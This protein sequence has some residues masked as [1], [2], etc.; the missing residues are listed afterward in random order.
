MTIVDLSEEYLGTY[1][2]CLE[3]WSPELKDAGPHKRCWYEENRGRGLRVKLAKDDRGLI[4]GM[5]QYMP[6][7]RSPIVGEG[8]YYIYCV[9]V[10]G[11]AMGVGNNQHRGIGKRLLEAA[12]EDARSLG[13]KG[14]VAWGLRLPLFMRSAW[15]KRQG[16][17]KVDSDGLAELVFKR[18]SPDAKRPAF[19]KRRVALQ[20]GK[21]RVKITSFINGWCPAQNLVHERAKR[22]AEE[23]PDC[24]EFERIDT[25]TKEKM[26]EYGLTDA[27]YIDGRQVRTG[28]PPSYEK[29]KK[30]VERRVRK[31]GLRPARA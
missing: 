16:Y 9:W 3:E 15:F 8:L 21:D 1:C 20:P 7:E 30:L 31:R 19:I 18:F 28:P 24:V 22:V 2:Q 13:A 5:I 23:S 10:H 12:E 26:Q 14:M 6:S 25:G 11:Y 29:I 4:V 17:K 27:L